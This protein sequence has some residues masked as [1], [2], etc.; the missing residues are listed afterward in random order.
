MLNKLQDMVSKYG[1]GLSVRDLASD[2]YW[3]L[4]AEG[5]KP[6]IVNERYI[7]IDGVTYQFRKTRTKGHWTVVSF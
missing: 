1:F 4:Y 7:E 6:C 2:I 5:F 3:A